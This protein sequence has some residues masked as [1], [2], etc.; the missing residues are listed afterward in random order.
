MSKPIPVPEYTKFY[1]LMGMSNGKFLTYANPDP[2][3]SGFFSTENE[4]LQV[5]LIE[6]IKSP[7]IRFEVFEIEWPTK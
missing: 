4:A 2:Q 3:S 1:A 7:N 6:T 5:R